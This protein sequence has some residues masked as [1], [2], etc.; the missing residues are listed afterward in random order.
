MGTRR[1]KYPRSL[2]P[3]GFHRSRRK[4]NAKLKYVGTSVIASNTAREC[5]LSCSPSF[6]QKSTGRLMRPFGSAS[7]RVSSRMPK[8]RP[9]WARVVAEGSGVDTTH[10]RS[11]DGV[12]RLLRI[13]DA[14]TVPGVGGLRG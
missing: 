8:Y 6:S 14:G 11:P 13:N 3:R 10:H 2:R 1:R 4:P 7:P 5:G 12:L 9:R